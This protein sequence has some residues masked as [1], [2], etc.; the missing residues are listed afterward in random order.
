MVIKC[1]TTICVKASECLLPVRIILDSFDTLGSLILLTES[2]LVSNLI[3]HVRNYKRAI[4]FFVC[5][6]PND[7]ITQMA[8]MTVL[9]L[10]SDISCANAIM[11]SLFVA[12]PTMYFPTGKMLTQLVH[13]M[14]SK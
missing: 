9:L 13:R 11:E 2:G 7:C 8:R 6:V 4:F 10:V 14:Q 1:A 12:P 5:L 3:I